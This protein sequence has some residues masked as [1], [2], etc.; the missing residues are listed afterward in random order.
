MIDKFPDKKYKVLDLVTNARFESSYSKLVLAELEI[1]KILA[2]DEVATLA[3]FYSLVTD[4]IE[5]TGI[6]HHI[7]W[8]Q[9][10]RYPVMD[11]KIGS[12]IEPNGEV[13]LTIDYD[14]NLRN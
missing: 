9:D 6:T 3:D 12:D 5:F 4:E 10:E 14:Y 2:Q 11:L 13:Y 1:T 8:K 7:Y